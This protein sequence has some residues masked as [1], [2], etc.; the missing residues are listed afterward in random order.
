VAKPK[1]DLKQKDASR[2]IYQIKVTLLGSEPPIWR[3]LLVPADMTLAHLHYVVQAAMG[4]HDDHLHEFRIG[5]RRFGIANLS[6]SLMGGPACINEEKVRIAEVLTRVGSK[7]E[8]T[9]DFGDSWEHVIKVEK[10]LTAAAGVLY[11]LCMDGQS[12]SPPEDCGGIG[13]FYHMLEAISDPDHPEHEDIRDW[14][15]DDFDPESF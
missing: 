4:W 2:A 3:R 10:V 11:P 8:Y 5:R 14:M 1:A 15:G 9:Y 6:D 7:A 13:G 12:N